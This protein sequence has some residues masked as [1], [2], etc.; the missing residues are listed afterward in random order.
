MA[1]N[2][3]IKVKQMNNWFIESSGGG[4]GLKIEKFQPFQKVLV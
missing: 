3:D 4:V 2:L 1:V